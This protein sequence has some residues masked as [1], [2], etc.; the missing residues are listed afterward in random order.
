MTLAAACQ[1]CGQVTRP[2]ARDAFRCNLTE[3]LQGICCAQRSAREICTGRF[4]RCMTNLAEDITSLDD[5]QESGCAAGK[6]V[7]FTQ[8]SNL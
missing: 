8:S 6:H 1:V 2:G 4:V 7:L 5:E 3:L